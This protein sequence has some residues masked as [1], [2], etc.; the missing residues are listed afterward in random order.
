VESKQLNFMHSKGNYNSAAEIGMIKN[1]PPTAQQIPSENNH[2]KLTSIS[3][4]KGSSQRVQSASSANKAYHTQS[5]QSQFA[6]KEE[7][8]GPKL[9]AMGVPSFSSH[10]P[11]STGVQSVKN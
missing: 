6:H 9:T 3:A 4:N 8:S 5:Y 7:R 11:G 1:A 10:L 2:S